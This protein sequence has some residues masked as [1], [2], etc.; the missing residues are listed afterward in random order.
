MTKKVSSAVAG[1]SGLV[2]LGLIGVVLESSKTEPDAMQAQST[3]AVAD[4]VDD[5][6]SH[7]CGRGFFYGWR[8]S[9]LE[10]D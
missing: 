7:R 3:V 1:I 2:A 5:C 8:S 10:T 9:L 6:P 4:D